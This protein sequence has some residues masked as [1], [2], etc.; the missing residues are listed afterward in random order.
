M[1]KVYRVMRPDGDAPMVGDGS[2]LLGVRVPQDI[3]PS[4]SGNVRPNEGGM[5]VS[6]SIRELPAHR[7][8]RR[9]EDRIYGAAGKDVDFVWSRGE[10]AFEN[11]PFA[12]RLVFRLDSPS[13]GLVE[14]AEEMT[15]ADYR[16]ALAA[17]RAEWVV[18]E[19]V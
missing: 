7:I 11:G 3:A 14:P 8:P 6:R 17:T 9:L 10:G 2:R 13:H 5:S 12:P 1:V 18:D 16:S 15:L 19:V 4:E